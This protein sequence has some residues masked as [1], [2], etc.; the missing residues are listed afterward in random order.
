MLQVLVHFGIQILGNG[1]VNAV[2]K[3]SYGDSLKDAVV[4]KVDSVT[5][6]ILPERA[7]REI[8]ELML[9]ELGL[10]PRLVCQFKNGAVHECLEGRSFTW[11]D[12]PFVTNENLNRYITGTLL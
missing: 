1:F 7:K 6:N 8:T 5:C 12:H 10:S 4:I 9:D 11:D 2:V 3:C